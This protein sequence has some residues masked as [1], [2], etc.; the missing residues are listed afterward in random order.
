MQ[1]IESKDA[2]H[3]KVSARNIGLETNIVDTFYGQFRKNLPYASETR[4]LLHGDPA[5][6]NM[7]VNGSS[8]TALIDWAQMEYGDWVCDFSRL[9]FWWPGRY[10][11]MRSF[12]EES[13]LETDGLEERKALYWAVNALWTIEFADTAKSQETSAWLREHLPAKIVER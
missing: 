10:G 13:R 2:E 11:D 1:D 6:D 5:F 8:V 4:R 9:D 3:F 12:A 7:L